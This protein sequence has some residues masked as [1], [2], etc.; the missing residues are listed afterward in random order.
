[1]VQLGQIKTFGAQNDEDFIQNICRIESLPVLFFSQ[2]RSLVKQFLNDKVIER[3]KDKAIS[4]GI[5]KD[6]VDLVDKA[7]HLFNFCEFWEDALSEIKRTE[8]VSNSYE[9]GQLKPYFI[10][11]SD[12]DEILNFDFV[13]QNQVV[14]VIIR[15]KEDGDYIKII[16]S[17]HGKQISYKF[18]YTV[19]LEE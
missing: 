10:I 5:P 6:I 7:G 13:Q 11:Y 16:S 9:N 19:T 2:D 15:A 8:F 17:A 4:L 1:M 14:D 18:E 3:Q 12:A